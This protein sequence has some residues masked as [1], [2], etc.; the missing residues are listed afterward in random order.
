L[1]WV[2]PRSGDNAHASR[3]PRPRAPPWADR[4][5]AG[6]CYRRDSRVQ[7]Q[8]NCAM[9]A[10]TWVLDLPLAADRSNVRDHA[11][12][13]GFVLDESDGLLAGVV[14]VTEPGVEGAHRNRLALLSV[15]GNSSR[16]AQFLW[17]DAVARLER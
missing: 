16:M 12:R 13:L 7:S 4:Q 3:R 17:S 15:W 5:G 9:I 1:F 14:G 6:H 8:H 11:A 2:H 10:L